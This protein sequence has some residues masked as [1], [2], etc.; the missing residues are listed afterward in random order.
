MK[1][2]AF[3]RVDAAQPER[4][5]LPDLLQGRL[6]AG[7]AAAALTMIKL[8][9]VASRMVRGLAVFF[10]LPQGRAPRPGLRPAR[11]SRSLSEITVLFRRPGARRAIGQTEGGR[12]SSDASS[13]RL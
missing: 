5:D 12:P 2:R 6:D 1:L 13:A 7:F 8:G 11:P 3:V 4:Q 9:A 10:D